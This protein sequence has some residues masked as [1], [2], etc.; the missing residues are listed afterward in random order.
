R[1]IKP[2]NIVIRRDGTPVLIDFGSARQAVTRQSRGLTAIVTE[3]YAPYEQY[4]TDS[5]QGPWSD[6]YALGAVLYHCVTGRRPPESPKRIAAHLRK[7]PDPMVPAKQAAAGSY[8]ESLLEAIDCALQ[9]EEA[10]RPQN[11]R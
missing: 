1:D 6:I 2:A 7:Q 9:I 10:R 8:G 3:G 4:E 11:V 5:N